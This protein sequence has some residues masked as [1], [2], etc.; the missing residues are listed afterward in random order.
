VRSARRLVSLRSLKAHLRRSNYCLN[1][2]FLTMNHQ[3]FNGRNL[4]FLTQSCKQLDYMEITSFGSLGD[5]LLAVLPKAQ[6]LRTLIIKRAEVSLSSVVKALS[7]CPQLQV[8]EFYHVTV[9]SWDD[10]VVWPQL[11][12]LTSL[13]IE[14]WGQEGFNLVCSFLAR[15]F[16]TTFC[17]FL[18]DVLFGFSII[19]S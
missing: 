12:S 1:R 5:S 15:Q 3:V 16:R 14:I 8:A 17:V 9:T 7:C 18:L 6:S 4:E 10:W 2:A 19:F 11:N 13:R